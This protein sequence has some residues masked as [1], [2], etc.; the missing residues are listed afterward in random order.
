MKTQKRA[1][2]AELTKE[3]AL[4]RYQTSGWVRS[5][6]ESGQRCHYDFKIGYFGKIHYL[7][8]Q[9]TEKI[10]FAQYY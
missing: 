10:I 8:R 4:E 3:V 5:E 9:E 6:K 1:Q 7:E 2:I